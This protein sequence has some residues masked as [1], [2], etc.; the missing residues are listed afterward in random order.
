MVVRFFNK[1]YRRAEGKKCFEKIVFGLK[2]GMRKC[3]DRES[4][5]DPH[6]SQSGIYFALPGRNGH[7]IIELFYQ[8]QPNLYSRKVI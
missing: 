7:Y 8:I 6:T 5:I 3:K 1:Q 4:C 2:W